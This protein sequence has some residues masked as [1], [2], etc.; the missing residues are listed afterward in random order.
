MSGLAPLPIPLVALALACACD[1]DVASGSRDAAPDVIP[2]SADPYDTI[3]PDDT[4]DTT[5]ADTPPHTGMI[6][7]AARAVDT[8]GSFTPEHQSG[9][10]YQTP[11][12]IAASVTALELLR[13]RDDAA[14]V[15]LPVPDAPREVDL[16]AGGELA[17]ASSSDLPAGT[18]RL[19][20][21]TVASSRYEV[22]ATAHLGF[23][24]PGA[25]TVDMALSDHTDGAGQR[26]AQ[27]Q[28]TA[29]FEA[30]G[31][32]ASQ[33]GS[34]PLNCLL[35]AWGGLP[36]TAG[37]RFT[38]TVPLPGGSLVVD[39]ATDAT[40]ELTFPMRDAF[41]WRDRAGDGFLAGALDMVMPPAVSELPDALTECHLF[42]SDRCEG[43][44]VVPYHPT[45]PMP[46]SAPLF[47]TD[48][49]G[50]V[51]PCPAPGEPG[52]GQD[53]TH[54]AH[55]PSYQIDGP[56]VTDLV[57]GL[58]WQ[59]ETAAASYDWWGAREHCAALTLGGHDD[60]RL[61]SRIELVSVLDFG[62]RDP[63]ID[64]TAFPGTPS[65]F[66]WTSSPVPFLSF[67]YGVRFELGFIYDHDPR[68]T[69]RVRC[70][71]G[72][73]EPPGERFTIEAEAGVVRDN[74][75]GLVWERDTLDAPLGWLDALARC[76]ALELAGFDDWR[77][78]TLKE[79]QTLIDERRLQP[80][81]DVHA[82]PDTPSEWYWSS[83]PIATHP[84]QAWATS[85]TD[86]YASIHA[87]AE[88]HRVRCV[89]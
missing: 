30:F 79:T 57:T 47:C 63:V 25:L 9:V 86:G 66:Y 24:V 43:E 72:A 68:S 29:T 75:T 42:L 73:Y 39:E 71:R 16:S 74:G 10:N 70:V 62:R 64:P 27:G 67:A 54:A 18:Y 13:A 80:S 2:D 61:P 22:A 38:V 17:R 48:G 85:T 20:R 82:F 35:S 87:G 6:V 53:A 84:D 15:D 21:I 52:F 83:T 33:S 28:Y 40:I 81:I 88:L 5:A 19:V 59:R 26:R 58:G 56:V 89:R 76:E 44:A 46:D 11:R 1:D 45:W 14:P 37:G 4:F 49:A 41:S 69:G 12:A 31:Q 55:P 7:I 36:T 77:L 60:W 3:T 23:T 78:P 32:R 50:L 34:T 8:C 65:D 51:D